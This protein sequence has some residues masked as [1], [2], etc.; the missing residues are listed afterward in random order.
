[1]AKFYEAAAQSPR[2]VVDGVDHSAIWQECLSGAGFRGPESIES[3]P[4]VELARRQH[5]A[6]VVNR[7]VACAREHGMPGLADAAPG[8]Q[9]DP[10]PSVSLPAGTAPAVL[11]Q[12]LDACPLD[13]PPAARKWRPV[14]RPW[15]RGACCGVVCHLAVGGGMGICHAGERYVSR[16]SRTT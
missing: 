14:E 8:G 2:L 13:T 9:E 10:F 3:D 11:E 12:V 16:A 7:W 15:R 1:L 5:Q 6:A 4:A